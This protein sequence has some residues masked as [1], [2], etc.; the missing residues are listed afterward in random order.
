MHSELLWS[1][2]QLPDEFVVLDTET[3]GL[4]DKQGL[5]SVVTIGLAKVVAGKVT[6]STEFKVRPQ[7]KIETEAEA[8]H[9]IC[10]RDAEGFPHLAESWPGLQE[11]IDGQVVVIH[12]SSFD[13]PLM[14]DHAERDSLQPLKPAGVVCSQKSTALWAKAIGIKCY[15]RGPSLD[16]LCKHLDV[17]SLRE[18]IDGI[19]GAEIDARMTAEAVIRVVQIS[20]E[21][22][23]G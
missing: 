3:T 18:E 15:D 1:L 9:G 20:S 5:P 2:A 19:H 16:R 14:V 6:E 21:D 7:R 10:Q 23:R 22:G 12:N 11:W 4:P 8:V 17:Q 13:W